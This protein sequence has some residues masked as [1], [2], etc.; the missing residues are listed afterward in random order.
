MV[1]W[2]SIR[3]GKSARDNDVP[4]LISYSIGVTSFGEPVC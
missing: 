4:L 1:L 2:T 3:F